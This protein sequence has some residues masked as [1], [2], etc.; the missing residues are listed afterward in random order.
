MKVGDIVYAKHP[1]MAGMTDKPGIIVEKQPMFKFGH[2]YHI[3]FPVVGLR[4]IQWAHNL[5]HIEDMWEAQ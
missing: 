1:K 4:W 2:R 3:L 5:I